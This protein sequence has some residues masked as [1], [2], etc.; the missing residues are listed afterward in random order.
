MLLTSVLN[1]ACSNLTPAANRAKSLLFNGAARLGA[2]A[3]SVDR[4]ITGG[5]IELS[6]L[7]GIKCYHADNKITAFRWA[8]AMAVTAVYATGTYLYLSGAASSTPAA[9]ATPAEDPLCCTDYI[10]NSD[11]KRMLVQKCNAA[12]TKCIP[13]QDAQLQGHDACL[14]S[15]KWIN[16]LS[17]SPF[18]SILETHFYYRISQGVRVMTTKLVC[19]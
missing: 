15:L 3:L 8:A 12:G 6:I 18:F 13:I 5:A 4:A 17:T 10:Y 19:D 16:Y 2:T 11:E 14:A 9:P 7:A 1:T